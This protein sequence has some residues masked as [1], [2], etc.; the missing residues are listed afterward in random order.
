[1]HD[2][3]YMEFVNLV[4]IDAERLRKQ[5]ENAIEKLHGNV[6]D[7]KIT[8]VETKDQK[9]FVRGTFVE[10]DQITT[11]SFTMRLD[12]NGKLLD[13]SIDE[14]AQKMRD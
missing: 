1:M 8:N 13:F 7:V 3:S 4:M 6:L 11:K 10:Y 2:H 12:Q 5:V 9:M 14:K